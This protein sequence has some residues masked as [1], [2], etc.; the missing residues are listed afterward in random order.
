MLANV[1]A[2]MVAEAAGDRK[3]A[4]RRWRQVAAQC[5]FMVKPLAA[6]LAAAGIQRSS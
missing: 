1:L 6:E 3:D 4:L 5:H 2:A